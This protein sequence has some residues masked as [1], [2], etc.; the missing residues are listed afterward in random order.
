MNGIGA[1]HLMQNLGRINQHQKHVEA[2]GTRQL[3][4]IL[5]MPPVGLDDEMIAGGDITV[6]HGGNLGPWIFASVLVLTILAGVGFGAWWLR[7][8]PPAP[9]IQPAP[10]GSYGLGLDDLKVY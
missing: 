5:G 3:A 1:A 4:K 7:T 9:I 10:Q 2:L 6:K 8:M